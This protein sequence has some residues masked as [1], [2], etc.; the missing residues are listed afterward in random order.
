MDDSLAKRVGSAAAAGWW[1]ILIAAIW[2]TASWLLWL[3][4]LHAQPGW[5]LTLWGGG[6]LGLG[7]QQVQGITLTFMAVA[8]LILMTVLLVTLWLTLWARRLKRI[9]E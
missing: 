6:E 5:V 9:C 2:L 8:K 4:L 3:W 7:W 1:T